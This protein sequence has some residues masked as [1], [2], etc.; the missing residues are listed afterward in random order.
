MG[1]V[2]L[3]SPQSYLGQRFGNYRLIDSLG[4]GGCAD[5]YL[6][7]HVYLETPGAVKIPHLEQAQMGVDMQGFSYEARIAA[8]LI[9]PHIV[10]VLEFGMQRQVPFLV[11]DYAPNGTLRQYHPAGSRLV[12]TVVLQ[13]VR[14][15]TAA[16]EYIHAN[17]FIHL[18]MKPENM[19]L[20]PHNEL[21]LSDFSIATAA[22]AIADNDAIVQ[23]T[24]VYMA[25]EQIYGN[26]CFQSDQYALA[27]VV[28]EWL[29]GYPPFQGET[30]EILHQHFHP[31]LPSLCA[32]TPFVPPAVENVVFKALAINP[33]ERFES[34]HAFANALHDAFER[35][36]LVVQQNGP[37]HVRLQ[38]LPPAIQGETRAKVQRIETVGTMRPR[39]IPPRPRQKRSKGTNSTWKEIA[40][41]YTVDLI[42]ATALASILAALGTA[43]L[44]LALLMALW[45]AVFPLVGSLI[46]ENT[47]L[48]FVAISI[49]VASALVALL[50]SS[51]V[52]FNVAYISLLLL[53]LVTAFAASIHQMQ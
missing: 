32:S 20:G 16:V 18:D 15:L 36:P 7:E 22:H 48:F 4:S 38:P 14:E 42:A 24:A 12:P 3:S 10:R 5:V 26:A 23:G 17:G 47:A 41:F 6:G 40:L 28:Y 46:R 30:H 50:A 21:W 35:R 11:M 39:A 29:S 1:N 2:K 37:Q 45:L 31:V 43:P 33:R 25:P 8:Q 19:L 51:I 27:V 52:A 9:H 53:S 44:L 49:T 34:V 13:Y